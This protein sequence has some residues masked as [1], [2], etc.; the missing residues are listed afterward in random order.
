MSSILFITSEDFEQCIEVGSLG[1]GS[2]VGGEGKKEKGEIGKIAASNR[3]KLSGGKDYRLACFARPMVFLFF[4]F[5]RQHHFFL[6]ISLNSEPGPRL[7]GW[8][9]LQGSTA[10]GVSTRNGVYTMVP[11]VLSV[12]IAY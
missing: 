12:T 4:F 8:L 3:S 7:T 11:D 9:Y 2:V 6:L 1:P 10:F 5:F